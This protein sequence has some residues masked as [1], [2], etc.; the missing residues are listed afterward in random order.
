MPAGTDGFPWWN[1]TTFYEI[2]VRS[3]YDSNEDGIG[4]INGITPSWITLMMGIPRRRPT[5]ELRASG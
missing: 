5:W 3:F 2:F 4:D 1:D